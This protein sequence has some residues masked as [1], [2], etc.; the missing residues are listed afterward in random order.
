[1]VT[2]IIVKALTNGKHCGQGLTRCRF[3]TGRKPVVCSAYGVE[4]R[5]LNA[6]GDIERCEE[7]KSSEQL[8]ARV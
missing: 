8:L 5:V 2:R 7:C 6:I 1:M 3:E 4:L